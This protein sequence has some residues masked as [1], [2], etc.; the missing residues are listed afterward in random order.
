AGDGTGAFHIANDAHIVNDSDLFMAGDIRANENIELTA[1]HTLFLREHNRLADLIHQ[2]FPGLSDDEVYQDARGIV[3]GEI[4]S[5]TFNEFLP[6]LLGTGVI[7]AYAGYSDTVNPDIAT[8][9]STAGFRVGHS[10]LAPDV[11]FLNPDASAKFPD[12][13]LANSFFNPPVV[14]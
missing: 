3:I 4:Q 14:R 8:E 12:V 6:A 10:L 2:Q 9:F 7:P 5:I 13:S 11:E 1:V